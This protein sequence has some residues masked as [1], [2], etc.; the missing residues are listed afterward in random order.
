MSFILFPREINFN[1]KDAQ[2]N[3]NMKDT[4]K[5]QHSVLEGWNEYKESFE[6]ER[7]RQTAQP[8]I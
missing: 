2:N 4:V 3:H 8:Y 5:D 7:G 6:Y 1:I